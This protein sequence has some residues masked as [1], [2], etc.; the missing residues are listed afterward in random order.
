MILSHSVLQCAIVHRP[1]DVSNDVMKSAILEIS[2]D[3]ITGTSPLD[4]VF[5]LILE[6]DSA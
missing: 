3:D 2:N 5:E 6:G 1:F 4:F